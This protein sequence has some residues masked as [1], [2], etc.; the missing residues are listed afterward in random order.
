[1][2]KCMIIDTTMCVS[3]FNCQV[4]CKDEYIANN[5]PP[6]SKGQPETGQFWMKVEEKIRGTVPKVKASYTPIP[7]MHCRDAPCMEAYPN[8]TYRRPDGIVM[9]DPEASMDEGIVAS[10]PYGAIYWN[11]DLG[12]GQKC[13]LCAHLLD[14]GWEEPRCVESCPPL[15]F[16]FGEYEDLQDTIAE[17]GA[18]P[19][20][21][22]FGTSPR[23]YYVGL[24]KP[25]IAGSLYDVRADECLEDAT[26]TAT[27]LRTGKMWATKTDNYGDFWL[28][29]LE[30][31]ALVVVRFEK[32]DYWPR[33]RLAYL[34]E[35]QN[36][37]DIRMWK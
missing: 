31:S 12:I 11:Q 18:M 27:S 13:T 23:V 6:Y 37:G 30:P 2:T 17:K 24:P 1:M 19:M 16:T 22:E 25:F 21:S 14:D 9:I 26:V 34:R 20:H 15:A 32:P 7:C 35:D 10:C 8:A 4:V 29:G 33:M 28:E 36:L 5:W 3:C